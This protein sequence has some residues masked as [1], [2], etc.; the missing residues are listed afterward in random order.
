MRKFLARIAVYMSVVVAII[1]AVQMLYFHF[2]P[3]YHTMNVPE[4]IQICNFGSSHGEC[5]FNYEDFRGKYICSNFAMGSQSILYDYRILQHYQGRLRPE[6]V[7]FITVSY[8]SFFGVPEVEGKEF[9]SKN[10]RYYKFL[11]RELILQYDL[12]T[13][14]Y[15]NYL[16]CLSVKGITVLLNQ[17]LGIDKRAKI[18]GDNFNIALDSEGWNRTTNAHDVAIDAS[19][20]YGRHISH[21]VDEGGHRLRRQESFEAIY[22]MIELCRKLGARPILV[23]VPYTR[24]YTSLIRKN[25]PEFFS[26]FY[27]VIDELRSNTGIEYY[28]YGF[29]ERFCDDYGLFINSDH[30]NREGARRFTNVLVHEVLGIDPD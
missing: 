5:G 9:L 21:R 15:V 28:D 4:N 29:D 23:T 11:P 14:I 17:I 22:G 24:E 16:P 30:M 19:Q 27:A 2:D 6:A 18:I 20:A 7:V 10:K 26:E 3:E 25:D 13:D 1:L 8:F 12:K